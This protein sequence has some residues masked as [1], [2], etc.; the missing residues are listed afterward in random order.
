[1]AEVKTRDGK[2]MARRIADRLNPD[3]SDFWKYPLRS[4]G[5]AKTVPNRCCTQI[6][7]SGGQHDGTGKAKTFGGESGGSVETDY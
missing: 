6:L 5:D 7:F 1:M 2:S 3:Y 4:Q